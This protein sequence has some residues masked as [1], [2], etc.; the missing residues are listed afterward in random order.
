MTTVRVH[1]A[2]IIGSGFAGLGMAIQLRDAGFS[3][4]VIL[5]KEGDVG[6]VWRDNRYPGAACDVPSHLYSFSFEPN[7]RW[8]RKF[9]GQA[10]IHA[11][12]RECAD[13][14]DLRGLTRFN[15]EVTAAAFDEAAGLWRIS[16]Q[17]GEKQG[18]TI[19]ARV[20]ISAVGQ[21]NRPATPVVQDIDKFR[22]EVFHSARWN[23]DIALEGKRIAVIGTGAS[24]IQIAPLEGEEGFLITSDTPEKSPEVTP[25]QFVM[26]AVSDTGTGMDQQTI[27]R[28][29]EPYVTTKTHG[30]GLGL[31]VVK[32]IADEHNARIELKNRLQDE[33][34]M[35]AQVSLSFRLADS[36][37]NLN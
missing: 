24:A 2:V 29:F 15:T 20:L 31:A 25:G 9:A 4:L 1:D 10:E 23:Y 14:H 8:T 27:A 34:V 33:V 21:L 37:L 16:T 13:K 18:E 19:L 26:I 11:Y 36:Q 28:A 3:D 6:G 12:L 17:H 22:G 32:K 30:T 5:E 7:T 35:G